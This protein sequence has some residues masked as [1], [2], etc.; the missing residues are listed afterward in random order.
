MNSSV[1]RTI[2]TLAGAGVRSR[3]Q[4]R[5]NFAVSNLL[6]GLLVLGDF[7]MVLAIMYRYE[8][9]AGWRLA[10]VALLSGTATASFGLFRSL[11][12]ELDTFDKYLV[13]GEFDNLLIRPWPT[14]LTLLTRGVDL[15]RLG[16]TAAGLTVILW[17][18][19]NLAASGELPGW[20]MLYLALLP[21]TGAVILGAI[22]LAACAAGFWITRVEELIIFAV[23][24][25]NTAGQYPLEIY[26][27]WLRGLLLGLLPAGYIS[28]VPV[29]YLL[30]KGGA[31]WH[32]LLPAAVALAAAWLA[33]RFWRAGERRY[34]STGS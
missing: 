24:A 3:M 17:A 34:Q 23:N 33:Y 27:G 20:G 31:W 12:S 1:L 11:G 19:A 2:L 25:P 6:Y 5:F 13:Q 16:P 7:L 26:P 4:Y 15:G 32:L 18:A 9:I 22:C 10:E 30:G 28:Y 14:L 21:V 8:W 29:R